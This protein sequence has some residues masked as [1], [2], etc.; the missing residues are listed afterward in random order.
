[1]DEA[2]CDPHEPVQDPPQSPDKDVVDGLLGGLVETYSEKHGFEL[3]SVRNLH[4][5]RDVEYEG[6][7]SF[8]LEFGRPCGGAG[9]H[10]R[11]VS[12]S[13][14]ASSHTQPNIPATHNKFG[15]K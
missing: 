15:H 6:V 7:E 11:V 4:G 13:L 9:N 8:R 14:P 2:S 1:M 3:L 5:L 12:G 10:K